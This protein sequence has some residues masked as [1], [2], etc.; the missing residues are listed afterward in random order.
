MYR[1]NMIHA[2]FGSTCSFR[3]T[4]E[5]GEEGTR[6]DTESCE[7]PASQIILKWTHDFVTFHLF[8]FS[9]YLKKVRAQVKNFKKY[10]YCYMGFKS[11][12]KGQNQRLFLVQKLIGVYL[13]IVVE[14]VVCSP[15]TPVSSSWA[16]RRVS[17]VSCSFRYSHVT[18]FRA[19]ECRW[20]SCVQPSSSSL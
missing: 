19:I 10:A 7:L 14:T 2:G 3:Y 5:R 8:T 20:R 18:E 17:L 13:G 11:N 15:T 9:V 4:W 12:L 16:S 6:R 1:E